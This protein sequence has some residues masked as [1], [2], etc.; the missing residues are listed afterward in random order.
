MSSRTDTAT[1]DADALRRSDGEGGQPLYV[2]LA[3]TIGERI[4]KGAYP[5]GT[6]LPTEAELGVSFGVSRYTVR[7]A[8]QHLRTQGLVS[9]RKGV[10]TRVEAQIAAPSYTQSMR[11]LGELLQYATETRLDVVK[12]EEVEARGRLAELLGCRPKKPWMRIAGIRHGAHGEPPHCFNEVLI[13]SAYSALAQEA[14]SLRTAIWSLIE[15]RFGETVVEV[16]QEIEATLLDAETARLLE[17]EPGEPALKFT[18]RYYVTGR[19]LVELSVS[20]HPA[21]RF[22]YHMTIRREGAG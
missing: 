3:Q 16:D 12:V 1:D 17:A 10:G 8:I 14:G 6:L 18:R 5:I 2:Q 9:A 11:S 21:D 19:R 20:I 13:D 15:T 7:Q 22:S 4:A